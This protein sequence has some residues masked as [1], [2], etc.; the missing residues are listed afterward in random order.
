MNRI[1]SDALSRVIDIKVGYRLLTV[2][3]VN[4]VGNSQYHLVGAKKLDQ[5]T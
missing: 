5:A 1:K 4:F 2:D 3:S